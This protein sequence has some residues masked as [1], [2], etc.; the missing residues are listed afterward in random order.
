MTRAEILTPLG[1]IVVELA[2]DRAPLSAASFLSHMDAGLYRGGSFYR[3]SRVDN[4]VAPQCPA[5]LVQGGFDVLGV[6]PLPRIA[7]EPSSLTGL[8]PLAGTI[9]LCRD[10]PGTAA[11][12]FF[13]NIIDNPSMADGGGRGDGCGVAIFGHVTE[14]MDVV[15][16]IH[17]GRCG[18][19][20]QGI[21]EIVWR[22]YLIKPI[23][24]V[25]VRRVAPSVR[26]P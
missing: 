3:A 4:E 14:G 22:Q 18:R 16:I 21:P 19:A 26:K 2:L 6:T 13:I 25:D 23:P 20:I 11:A 8:A 7:H 24:I 5:Q 10:A 9:G 1:R 15:R 12:E 17:G